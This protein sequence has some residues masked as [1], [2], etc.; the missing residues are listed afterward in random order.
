VVVDHGTEKINFS[1]FSNS[2]LHVIRHSSDLWWAGAINKGIGFALSKKEKSDLILIINDD[3]S[4]RPDYL[5]N[6]V[7]ASIKYPDSIIG[8]AS[9]DKKTG[10]ILNADAKLKPFAARL[11]SSWKGKKIDEIK[12]DYVKSDVLPGRGMQIPDSVIRKIG[13]FNDEDLPHYGADTEFTWR[14]KLNG[15]DVLCSKNCRVFTLPKEDSLYQHKKKLEDFFCENKKPGNLIT[16]KKMAS[17]CFSKRYAIYYTWINFIR[18]LMAY[19][20]RFFIRK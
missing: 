9:V 2:K 14:A 20:K 11:K 4:L 5:E 19:V 1:S 12:D 8:S 18:L 17:L 7:N 13:L 3:V 10:I 6:I 16:I 15:I